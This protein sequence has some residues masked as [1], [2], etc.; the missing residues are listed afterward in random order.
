MI[1]NNVA[2]RR[3]R[4]QAL[5]RKN[6]LFLGYVDAAPRAAML[7]TIMAEGES[8]IGSRR[9]VVTQ[10]ERT[11]ARGSSPRRARVP[12]T[13]SRTTGYSGNASRITL[14]LRNKAD[15][16]VRGMSR[17]SRR[18]APQTRLSNFR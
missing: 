5:G 3:L 2:G 9:V 1:D 16:P 6:W 17:R 12:M 11:A 18:S 10:D 13:G 4:D 15:R 8:V 14:P 7:S